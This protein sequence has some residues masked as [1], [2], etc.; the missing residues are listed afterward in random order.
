MHLE[1]IHIV[2]MLGIGGIGMSAIARYF[3][4]LG[5]K[6]YGYD[7]TATALTDQLM[8]EGIHI[9]FEEDVNQ[10]PKNIDLVIYTPAIP[11]T[12]L[13]FQYFQNNDIELHKRAKIL[14][15]ITKDQFTIAI[16][17]SHGKT[18][19]T[20]MLT[21]LL[22]HSGYGCT[23]FIGGICAN[24]DS[25]FIASNNKVYVIEADEYDRS[26]HQLRPDIAVVT[27]IDD[28]HLEIYGD[29]EHVV[30]AY[31]IFIS[32][33]KKN[34]QLI[35]KIHLPILEGAMPSKAFSYHLN[36]DKADCL[37]TSITTN[38]G[39]YH[40]DFTMGKTTQQGVAATLPLTLNIGGLHNVEN[41]IAAVQV[42]NVLGIEATKIQA[43]LASFKG[44]KRRFEYILQSP[45]L[46][47]IDDYAHHPKELEALIHSAKSLF[48]NKQMLVI[49]QPHLY[50]RTMH[51]AEGFAQ[52][53]QQAHQV[54][55]MQI[56]PA[57]E[58]P[59]EGVTSH[60]IGQH[61]DNTDHV[62]Y[63]KQNII[64]AAIKQP[65]DLIITAGAGDISDIVPDLKDQ[66]EKIF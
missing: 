65:F 51:L 32:K 28:D 14:G 7:R 41:S 64:D 17:G 44:I 60:L 59:I 21:H 42:A 16:A 43:A 57:R 22:H 10:I 37:A 36:D 40:Y 24:Y 3:N 63:N 39:G 8:E 30:E 27:A 25:N 5:V 4:H 61:L 1:N 29:H 48:P 33:I 62:L 58:E 35:H 15:D 34:G 47:F 46:T 18:T 11:K 23:A 54:M 12:N 66:L 19:I 9:H 26:F 49:F 20:S 56:Y 38:N 6:V 53:L 45:N 50:T 13:E 31:N 2:Y 52:A 55:L